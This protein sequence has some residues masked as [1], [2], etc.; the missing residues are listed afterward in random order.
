MHEHL[1]PLGNSFHL[2]SH[3]TKR[4]ISSSISSHRASHTGHFIALSA[5]HS[6]VH[7]I[8]TGMSSYHWECLPTIHPIPAGMSFQRAC[9]PTTSY[10][11]VHIILL[12]A[13]YLT[14]SMFNGCTTRP[15]IFLSL[16]CFSSYCCASHLTADIKIMNNNY[17]EGKITHVQCGLAFIS[18][19]SISPHTYVQWFFIPHYYMYM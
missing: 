2:A 5:P 12:S 19:A 16:K 10:S 14:E 3:P 11:T 6:I 7:L 13:C 18:C 15:Y 4:L 1:V 17:Q 9:H 8:P